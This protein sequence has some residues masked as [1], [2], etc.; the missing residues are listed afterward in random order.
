M[1][2]A[3]VWKAKGAVFFFSLYFACMFV[4]PLYLFEVYIYEPSHDIMVYIVFRKQI[5]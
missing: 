5:F 2:T 1:K 3:Q 4:L